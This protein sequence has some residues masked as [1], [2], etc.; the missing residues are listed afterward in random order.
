MRSFS[1]IVWLADEQG[2]HRFSIRAES[3]DDARALLRETYGDEIEM[4]MTD[5]EAARKIR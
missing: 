2:Q 4:S 1:G 5:D 3:W